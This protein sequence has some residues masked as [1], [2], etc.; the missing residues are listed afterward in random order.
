[1][2]LEKRKLLTIIIERVM[3]PTLRALAERAG[4]LGCTVEKV[5]A[6]YGKHGHREGQIESDQTIKMLIVAP[7][8]VTEIILQD[9]ERTLQPNYAVL[10]FQHDVEVLTDAAKSVK[11]R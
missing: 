9:V 8:S 2:P 10:A 7:G 4:A 6:G 5:S 3:E 11:K 1:M